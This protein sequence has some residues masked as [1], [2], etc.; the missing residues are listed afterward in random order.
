MVYLEKK[1]AF[2]SGTNSLSNSLS[3]ISIFHIPLNGQTLFCN[4]NDNAA[5]V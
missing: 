4:P 1:S 3:D 5:Y 2:I